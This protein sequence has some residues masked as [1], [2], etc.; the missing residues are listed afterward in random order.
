M[1]QSAGREDAVGPG[2]RQLEDR[3]D[4]EAPRQIEDARQHEAVAFVRVSRTE[5]DRVPLV[6]HVLRLI[7]EVRCE[8]EPGLRLRERV[9]RVQLVLVRIALA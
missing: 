5:V 7:A 9:V 4:L 2:R 6:E 8:A 1:S 3:R